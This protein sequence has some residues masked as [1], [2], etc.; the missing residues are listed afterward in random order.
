[1]RF[2]IIGNSGSGKSTLAQRIASDLGLPVLDLDT[3]AWEP[4]KVAQPRNP[5][6]ALVDVATFCSSHRSWIVE[7]CYADLVAKSL[8]Y[9]PYL[10]F[11]EPGLDQCILNCK[12]RPWEPHKY[13]SYEE[14][15]NKLNFLLAWV[16]DYYRREGD[17]S[18]AGHQRLY[19]AYCG[20][21]TRFTSFADIEEDDLLTKLL[22]KSNSLLDMES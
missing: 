16:E 17:M 5:S 22:K 13:A 11:L 19:D 9:K 12:S 20:V 4:G 21:K 15:G 10:L 14:Q 8:E 18:L 1:M 7:G 3:V 2:A 6:A